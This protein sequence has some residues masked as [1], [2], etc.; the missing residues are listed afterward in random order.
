MLAALSFSLLGSLAILI[1]KRLGISISRLVSYQ[2]ARIEE[3]LLSI[4]NVVRATRIVNF[5]LESPRMRYYNLLEE[6]LPCII[7]ELIELSTNSFLL[8]SRGSRSNNSSNVFTNNLTIIFET[9]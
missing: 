4:R 3:E 9:F 7:I 2:S 1:T 5:M 6:L 8:N